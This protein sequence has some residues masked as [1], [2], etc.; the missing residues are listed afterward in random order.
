[1][2][3][4]SRIVVVVDYLRP[5]SYRSN[6]NQNNIQEII[7]SLKGNFG[8]VASEM[9]QDNSLSVNGSNVR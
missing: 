3:W 1:M 9:L 6:K 4:S 8:K 2:R 7:I 5:L